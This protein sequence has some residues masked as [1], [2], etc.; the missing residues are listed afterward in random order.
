MHIAIIGAGAAGVFAAARAAEA[1]PSVKITIWEKTATA[2]AKV[3]VSGGGRCNVTHACFEPRLLTS[4]YPRGGKE[5]LGPFSRFQPRDTMAWFAK[6]GV[7]L[8]V[9]NDGRVFPQSDSSQTIID[10]LL[11]ELKERNVNIL[12]NQKITRIAKEEAKFFLHLASGRTEPCDRLL[13]ATGSSPQGHRFAEQ[14]GHTTSASV[15]SLFTF[16]VPSSPLLDLAGVSIE[17]VSMRLHLENT[18]LTEEG[19][20]LLTH[21]GFS[22]PAALKLSAW[23]ARDLFHCGYHAELIINWL[24]QYSSEELMTYL[25]GLRKTNACSSLAS[26]SNFPLAKSLWRRLLETAGL[27]VEKPLGQLSN[28]ELSALANKL[29]EDHYRIEGK[30]TYK[31]EFV[32]CG[33]VTLAEVNFKTMESR[34]CP[35]LFFAG[36]ILDIDAITGGFNFQNGWTTGWL[37]GSAL[38]A[39]SSH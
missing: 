36:E 30:T 24:P 31:Q 15:P 1:Y 3:K 16:N 22:G 7:T 35:A 6:R 4:Y 28:Q 12:Q 33:G 18:I 27:A 10:C 23:G 11:K 29:Q 21:W 26:W 19:S 13:L 39:S 32:T 9:E 2:L 38:A 8:K 34:R 20:L 17:K 37:A 5:L 25:K 14:L